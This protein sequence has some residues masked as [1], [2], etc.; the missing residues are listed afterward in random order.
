MITRDRRRRAAAFG[1]MS[2]LRIRYR[3][4]PIV[5]TAT[6]FQGRP[7][8]G[9]D[10]AADGKIEGRDGE[11]MMFLDL[12]RGPSYHLALFSGTELEAVGD[13]QLG[14]AAATLIERAL[15]G[16]IVHTILAERPAGGAGHLDVDRYLHQRYGFDKPGYVIIRPDGYVGHIRLLSATDEALAW[17]NLF[18]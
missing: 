4:S 7:I 10:R 12:C 11:T 18:A 6:A 8:Q 13:E 3:R 17:L 15:A 1:F 16:T 14:N 2:Q 9:A 5:Q